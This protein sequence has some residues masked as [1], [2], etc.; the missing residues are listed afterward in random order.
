[1]TVIRVCFLKNMLIRTK[2]HEHMKQNM[3]TTHGNHKNKQWKTCKNDKMITCKKCQ[4]HVK[5]DVK[6]E[7]AVK[8]VKW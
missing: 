2:R 1:M 5:N 6:Y 8:H 4:T 3:R 7:K